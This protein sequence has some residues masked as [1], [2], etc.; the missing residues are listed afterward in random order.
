M[1]TKR[2]RMH[3]PDG[4]IIYNTFNSTGL[5]PQYESTN[6]RFNTKFGKQVNE[7]VPAR[8]SCT[9]AG[10]GPQCCTST[11][12]LSDINQ[13]QWTTNFDYGRQLKPGGRVTVRNP[14]GGP[15][16]ALGKIDD[17]VIS[18]TNDCIAIPR[19][20]ESPMDCSGAF[21]INVE[22]MIDSGPRGCPT[23]NTH[24]YSELYIQ[25]PQD[26]AR[27]THTIDDIIVVRVP[28]TGRVGAPYRAP[29]AGWRKS[30][31][32]CS[33]NKNCV[34]NC[35]LKFGL[36]KFLPP[37]TPRV[38]DHVYYKTQ[39]IGEVASVD[40]FAPQ[41]TNYTA[42]I[43]IS[44][45]FDPKNNLDC[46]SGH[47]PFSTNAEATLTDVVHQVYQ[48]ATFLGYDTTL[49]VNK[50]TPLNDVYKDPSVKSCG[51]DNR[52]CYDKRIRSGMQPK[53]QF[54]V[55]YTKDAD[56]SYTKH[57]KLLCPPGNNN[58]CNG[59][60]KCTGWQ[61]PYA[62]SY[63]QYN[64]NR[65][66]NTY[67]RGLEK[68]LD[69]TKFGKQSACPFGTNCKTLYKN[70]GSCCQKSQY[71]KSSGNACKACTG[72]GSCDIQAFEIPFYNG[73]DI[74]V[75]L[76]KKGERQPN[77]QLLQEFVGAVIDLSPGNLNIGTITSVTI[78][79]LYDFVTFIVK[80]HD[81]SV[82][83][84]EPTTVS[85]R[86]ADTTQLTLTSDQVFNLSG[87][88]VTGS[89][90]QPPK[91]AITVWKPNNDKFKV[92]GAVTSG[93]R[94]ERL[95]LDTIKT[96]NSKCKKGERCDKN[97]NGKGPYFAG[98][99]RF[100]KWM[101]NGRHREIVCGNKYRQQPLG[102]PQLTRN[103]RSTRSNKAPSHWKNE[104]VRAYGNWQRL[105]SNHR[106][107][108][109][110]CPA[111]RCN[112]MLCPGEG[113][114]VVASD[115]DKYQPSKCRKS[116]DLYLTTDIPVEEELQP[117]VTGVINVATSVNW[118]SN[119]G[120]N[121]ISYAGFNTF[122]W[123]LPGAP[124]VY[125]ATPP[126]P[127]PVMWGNN[128]VMFFTAAL[129]GTVQ[130]GGGAA[131]VVLGNT[132]ALP[133]PTSV[134]INN[135]TTNQPYTIGAPPLSPWVL[136]PNGFPQGVY[137]IIDVNAPGQLITVTIYLCDPGI[138]PGVPN[139]GMDP[140][141]LQPLSPGDE[142]IITIN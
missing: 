79:P 42:Y 129:G 58:D 113:E 76:T 131:M 95:K 130:G 80:L 141:A 60:Q 53:Q 120:L 118:Q 103:R 64:R 40:L 55:E 93:G 135:L 127:N 78:N 6:P 71:R 14:L 107:P 112:N 43:Y 137:Q 35:Y 49:C 47:S 66:L 75:L 62:F 41:P 106:A 65:A 73:T 134:T 31:K 16:I 33:A 86:I 110:A 117:G 26:S 30:L 82:R 7:N 17:I 67:Q 5:T 54:C 63:Y 128:E 85:L 59:N 34:G 10:C 100:D 104:S 139:G 25:Q 99:P 74:W 72:A 81:C 52:V 133:P 20:G 56:G 57:K 126:L 32:C 2:T 68:N 142:N 69:V 89:V 23:V 45:I 37:G 105:L 50:S 136:S 96:A 114:M 123:S 140:P 19:E 61:K 116:S 102:I 11:V 44:P 39:Y 1:R 125:T 132:A 27:Y 109:C 115:S 12:L 87:Q 92:Q 124:Y 48:K 15:S 101:F 97:G 77:L 90:E 9:I 111:K 8:D 22:I 98:K 38:G 70:N 138:A 3:N 108:G 24:I 51:K 29:I 91:H 28:G 18:N 13:T 121:Y 21:P 46:H 119:G 83:I 94:L 4:T 36:T 122:N 84:V 88:V